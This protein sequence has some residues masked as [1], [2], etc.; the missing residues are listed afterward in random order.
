MSVTKAELKRINQHLHQTLQM[1]SRKNHELNAENQCLTKALLEAI[2]QN[3]QLGRRFKK[4]SAYVKRLHTWAK[5][6]ENA[7]GQ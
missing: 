3:E 1:L 2:Q 6:R 5:K 7:S 4:L